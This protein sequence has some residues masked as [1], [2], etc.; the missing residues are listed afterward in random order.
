MTRA[1]KTL[2]TI[3]TVVALAGAVAGGVAVLLSVGSDVG[4]VR[5]DVGRHEVTLAAHSA[6]IRSLELAT[7]GL[8]DRLGELVRRLEDLTRRIERIEPYPRG[9]TNPW[10][11]PP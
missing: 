8:P 6:Q 4:T 9:P 1:G 11:T 5:A 3:A 10:S 2:T 7:V